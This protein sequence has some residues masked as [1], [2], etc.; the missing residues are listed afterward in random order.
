MPQAQE[1]G[2][3]IEAL[4]QE[5]NPFPTDWVCMTGLSGTRNRKEVQRLSF[6]LA[7]HAWL[8]SVQIPRLVWPIF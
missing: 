7:Q 2:T 5:R 6:G 3:E 8:L 1:R 4:W